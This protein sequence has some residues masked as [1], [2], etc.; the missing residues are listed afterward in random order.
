M[1]AQALGR[2]VIKPVLAGIFKKIGERET[3]EEG[4]DELYSFQLD[5][6][7]IDLTPWTSK[8]SDN[9]HAYI[10]HGLRKAAKRHQARLQQALPPGEASE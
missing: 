8:A 5:N 3:S 1:C 6:P 9:F 4:L 7:D 10:M 2:G